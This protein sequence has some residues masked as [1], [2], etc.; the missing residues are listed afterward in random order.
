[1]LAH[2]SWSKKVVAIG[3]LVF[4]LALFAWDLNTLVFQGK[5]DVSQAQA[6]TKITVHRGKT[7]VI[8]DQQG[9]V[10]GYDCKPSGWSCAI[11]FIENLT[12]TVRFPWA[13][14]DEEAK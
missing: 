4:L 8:K 9:N 3:V 6:A 13:A 12:I 7:V 1:M 2:G 11:I 5:T 10:I 14:M